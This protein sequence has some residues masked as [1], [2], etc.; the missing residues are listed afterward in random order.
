MKFKVENTKLSRKVESIKNENQNIN[1]MEQEKA[2]LK[3]T[4]A[5]MKATIENLQK[6]QSKQV[7]FCFRVNISNSR[8]LGRTWDQGNDSEQRKFETD[9]TDGDPQ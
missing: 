1:I 9:K 5:Q 6:T 7:G 8:S 2:N 3:Q 4:V